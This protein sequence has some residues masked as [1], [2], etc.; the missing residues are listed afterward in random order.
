MMSARR[1]PCLAVAEKMAGGFAG[2]TLDLRA[3]RTLERLLAELGCHQL[4]DLE[5]LL[6]GKCE[7]LVRR[8]HRLKSAFGALATVDDRFQRLGVIADI[9]DDAALNAHCL[10]NG[11]HLAFETLLRRC[12]ATIAPRRSAERRVGKECASTCRF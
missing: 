7:Q 9:F 11:R 2:F 5:L 4:L 10:A 8:L 3:F 12:N 1:R 6:G